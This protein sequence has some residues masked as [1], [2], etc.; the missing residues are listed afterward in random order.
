MIDTSRF[1]T[2]P[3][4]AKYLHIGIN[5]TYELCKEADFPV[6][7]IGNRKLIDKVVLDEIWIPN[8]RKTFVN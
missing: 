5:K 8:K 7:K 1:M 2:V 4:T 3:E 6:I